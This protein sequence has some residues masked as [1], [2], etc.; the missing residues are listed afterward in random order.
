MTILE[1]YKNYRADIIN[2]PYVIA[3]AGVNHEGDIELAK[4]LIHEAAEGGAH[5][6][7]FQTYK[8][9]TIASRHSPSYWDLSKEP[10]RSQFELFKKYDKFWKKEFEQLKKEC[11]KSGIEFMST[12]FDFNAADFLNDMMPAF[13][14]SS[15]DLTNTP[16]IRHI[17]KF[18]K[19]V[20]LSTGASNI[21]EIIQATEVISEYGVPLSL[22]HCI[23]NYPTIDE[24]AN[25]GMI[26]DLKKKFPETIPGYS[27]HTMPGNMD[28]LKTA[29]LLGAV[30]LEKHFTF[31]KTLP[32][33]DHYHAMDK[34]DLKL[35][36]KETE[37]VF[38]LL[39]SFRKRP[40]P[41]EET[42][43]QNAR[44]SLVLSK[45]IQAGDIISQEHLTYKRPASGISPKYIDEVIGK[46]AVA[47]IEP[48]TILKWNMIE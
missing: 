39:G 27:D 16:F 25:L 4:R 40:I 45:K 21:S 46:K 29:Y 41:T 18:G 33:N 22:M 1:V 5:A 23:L 13:K 44:R 11:D 6:I 28:V 35:F 19:P 2:K 43:R 42:S 20:I 34:D 48:D 17:C 3:E 47:D 14:I 9:E 32:G 38:K 24:N 12:P 8:A 10:T 31:D 15:S 36:F 37:R 30:I 7:K 26:L